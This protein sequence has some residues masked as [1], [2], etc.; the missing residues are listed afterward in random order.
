MSAAGINYKHSSNTHSVEGPRSVFTQVLQGHL[1]SSVLDIG[2]GTGTWVRAALDAGVSDVIGVDGVQIPP[3][4]LLFPHERFL[5]RDLTAPLDLGRRFDAAICLEVGEHLERAYANTLVRTLTTHSDCVVFSA[6]APGQNG[7]HHVN[8]EAIGEWQKRF[9]DA[10]FV[11]DDEVRWRLWDVAALEPWY[12]QNMFVARK[13]PEQASREPR[14]K[15][16][17]HP[18]MLRYFTVPVVSDIEHGSMSAK[19]YFHATTRA[20]A[21]KV[22]RKYLSPRGA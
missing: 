11:C 4:Q 8:C 13:C 10:G 9:N 14:L 12:R 20:F 18:A 15:S 5:V 16:V 6:A 22:R 1:P 2:C 21:A 17:I 3:E 7:Q 19:W